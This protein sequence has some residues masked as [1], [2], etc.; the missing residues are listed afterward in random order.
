MMASDPR[1]K[2]AN[3]SLLTLC[4]ILTDNGGA[5]THD[6]WQMIMSGAIKPLFDEI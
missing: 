5:F 2:I 4:N 3:T 1:P 6:F